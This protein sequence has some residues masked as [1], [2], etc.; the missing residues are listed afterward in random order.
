M[1]K[2]EGQKFKSLMVAKYLMENCDEDSPVWMNDILDYL[3]DEIGL[4]ADRRSVY[5]DIEA[6]RQELAGNRIRCKR[7]IPH[8]RYHLV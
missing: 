8:S 6:L 3:E 7:A 5:R 2:T 4:P 1:P